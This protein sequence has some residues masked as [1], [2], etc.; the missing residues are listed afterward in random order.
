M[1]FVRCSDRFLSNALHFL[2]A[3]VPDL[4]HIF[5]RQHIKQ[6]TCEAIDIQFLVEASEERVGLFC[7]DVIVF[8]KSVLIDAIPLILR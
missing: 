6:L 8:N 5:L 2:L 3:V 4:A 1:S 7:N